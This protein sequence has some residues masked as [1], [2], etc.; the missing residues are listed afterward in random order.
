[1]ILVL[2]DEITQDQKSNIRSILFTEGCVVREMTATGQNIIGALG[3]V[4]QNIDFFEK[5]PGVAKVISISTAFKLVSRQM[6]P[7]DTLVQIGDVVVG[8]ERIAIIAGPCAIES[9]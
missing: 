2:E 4:G 6:H 8:G 5:I 1:M 3:K 9:R 7:E